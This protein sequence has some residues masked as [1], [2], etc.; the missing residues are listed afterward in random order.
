MDFT[1][2]FLVHHSSNNDVG[3]WIDHV[4]DHFRCGGHV[5]KGHVATA[6]DVDDATFGSVD[7][8]RLQ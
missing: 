8:G 6:A 7:A 3:F 5:L 1:F 2:E 4:V